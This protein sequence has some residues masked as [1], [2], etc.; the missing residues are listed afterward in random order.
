MRFYIMVKHGPLAPTWHVCE[1]CRFGAAARYYPW[2]VDGVERMYESTTARCQECGTY[3]APV[4]VLRACGFCGGHW[5]GYQTAHD[6]P[7]GGDTWFCPRHDTEEKRCINAR[8]TKSQYV[9]KDDETPAPT[10]PLPIDITKMSDTQQAELL[11]QLLA[12]GE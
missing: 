8:P 6:R 3:G 2:Y 4:I 10:T 12:Y 7:G 9:P 5:S 1:D 11:A